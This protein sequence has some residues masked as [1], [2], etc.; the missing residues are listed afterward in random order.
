MI[1]LSI[2]IFCNFKLL[3]AELKCPFYSYTATSFLKDVSWF[4][5]QCLNCEA[6]TFHLAISQQAWSSITFHVPRIENGNRIC[7][8]FYAIKLDIT[9]NPHTITQYILLPYSERLKT[10]TFVFTTYA[11]RDWAKIVWSSLHPTLTYLIK[12]VKT[13]DFPI[14]IFVKSTLWLTFKILDISESQF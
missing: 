1:L 10:K 7:F 4:F 9:I 12:S 6:I 13:L 11:F 5:S 2:N 14:L 8:N 3:Y